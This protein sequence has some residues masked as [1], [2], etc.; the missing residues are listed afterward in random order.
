M[1]YKF[2]K[3][4][5]IIFLMIVFCGLMRA[6]FGIK[7][8]LAIVNTEF[9]S[10][11]YVNVQWDSYR[12]FQAGVFF[13]LNLSDF[14]SIQPEIMYVT[15]GAGFT[16]TQILEGVAEVSLELQLK[17]EYVECP[18]LLKVNFPMGGNIRPGI[19]GGPYVAYNMKASVLAI[20]EVTVAGNVVESEEFD[21]E[22][23]DVEHLDY[24]FVVG[25]CLELNMGAATVILD[26]RY[27]RGLRNL[28][29]NS[30]IDEVAKNQTIVF[31]I[32]LGF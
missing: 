24:G 30:G 31:M 26:A 5:M 17:L 14:L 18:I 27:T 12:R 22:I 7:G 10:A 13:S 29:D 19:F 23:E 16:E 3:V 32:G 2:S 1:T 25:G 28:L 11:D 4:L 15:K 21:E 6:E 20:G 9:D 8:G